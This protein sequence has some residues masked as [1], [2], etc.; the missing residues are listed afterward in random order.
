MREPRCRLVVSGFPEHQ[1]F[2]DA[3]QIGDFVSFSD[4][5]YF[6]TAAGSDAKTISMNWQE[7]DTDEEQAAPFERVGISQGVIQ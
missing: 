7:S 1:S 5:S 3:D 4:L 2:P 6:T